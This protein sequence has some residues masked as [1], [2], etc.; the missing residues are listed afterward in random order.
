M[1]A[2]NGE[3]RERGR[4]SASSHPQLGGLP[5]ARAFPI[6]PV[7]TAAA[8]VGLLDLKGGG[9]PS[10]GQRA[11]FGPSLERACGGCGSVCQRAH[12][13]RQ[14]KRASAERVE[15]PE[16]ALGRGGGGRARALGVVGGVGDVASEGAACWDSIEAWLFWSRA[17]GWRAE[18]EE[19]GAM[20]PSIDRL[21]G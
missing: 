8:W 21:I 5:P 10:C 11:C 3:L 2:A 14:Q 16:N 15:V 7:T 20:R 19:I 9:A 4:V 13:W 1:R 17:A 6:R 12:S 18:S